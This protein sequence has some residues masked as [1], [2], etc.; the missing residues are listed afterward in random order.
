MNKS[1]F[2]NNLVFILVL[3]MLVQIGYFA[4]KMIWPAGADNQVVAFLISM[5]MGYFTYQLVPWK[6]PY[7]KN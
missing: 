4:L 3:G 1:V 2:K 5:V 7:D 6:S